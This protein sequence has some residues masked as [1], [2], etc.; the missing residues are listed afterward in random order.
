MGY[1]GLTSMVGLASLGHSVIGVDTNENRVKAL[2]RGEMPIF[3]PGLLELFESNK[4]RKKI[5]LSSSYELVDEK[6]DFAFLCVATPST[7]HGNADLRFIYSALSSLKER[8]RKGATVVVK[9]TVPIGTCAIFSKELEESEINVASNPEFLAEGTALRDFFSPSRVVVGADSS[10]IAKSVMDLYENIEGPKF[11]CGLASAETIKHASNSFLAIKL[12]FVN[13]LASIC[14]LTGSNV[15]DVTHGMSLDSRIGSKFLMPGPGWGGSCFPKDTAE[16][17]YSARK[18][19]FPMRT[20]E[21]AIESNHET[22]NRIV[23]TVIGLFGENIKGVKIAIWGLAFKANT[24]DTRDSPALAVAQALSEEGAVISAFDPIA[25]P[26][27]LDQIHLA[28]SAL[29]ACEGAEALLVLTEWPEFAS[30]DPGE[31]KSKMKKTP[32][33]FD[34]RRVLDRG[35]WEIDFPRLKVLGE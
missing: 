33:V 22:I 20:V 28:K 32:L 27:G 10:A 29:E 26:Q 18:L 12:S 15:Q 8:L 9:S 3:E 25:K 7:E 13:E 11:Q 30:V 35:K 14:E 2:T 1:V 16:L 23:R 19:G 17:A 24:D 5:T 21:A 34:T 4:V 6:I 31:A